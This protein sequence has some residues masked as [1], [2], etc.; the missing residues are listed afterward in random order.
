MRGTLRSVRES[1][2]GSIGIIPEY[3]TAA[4]PSSKVAAEQLFV[5]SR[6]IPCFYNMVSRLFAT[7]RF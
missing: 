1:S 5:V 4:S 2:N 7:V 6:T 3:S